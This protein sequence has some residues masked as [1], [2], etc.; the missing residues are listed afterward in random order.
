[1]ARE[2]LVVALVMLVTATSAAR[3]QDVEG[4]SPEAQASGLRER[5]EEVLQRHEAT[6]ATMQVGLAVLDAHGDVVVSRD[7]DVPLL[8]ASTMKLLT[9]VAVADN[10]D[11]AVG[12]T[13][14]VVAP[15]GV[16]ADGVAAE[17]QV[18]GAGDPALTT[19]AFRTHVHPARPATHLEDLADQVVAAGVQRITGD[20]VGNA[21]LFGPATVAPGW[22]D[23]Y[24]ADF[25]ARHVASLAT[26]T[27]LA[28]DTVTVDGAEHL[29]RRDHAPSP[30]LTA[31]WDF[32]R[33][34]VA[35]GVR[36]DG[37]VTTSLTS[38]ETA[39][40]AEEV[41]ATTSPP[42]ADLV[43]FM[44]EQSDNHMADTLVR[45][46]AAATEDVGSW[47]AAQ[48]SLR[49]TLVAR[50]VP[51]TGLVV[52]DGSGLSR[53]DRVTPLTLAGADQ[54]MATSL[55]ATWDDW[56]STAG[57]DG[58]FRRRLRDTVGEARFHA[59]SGSLADVKAMVGHVSD[60]DGSR[61]HFA[62]VANGVPS[63]NAWRVA[64][65]G[66]DLVLTL[67][68]MEDGCHRVSRVPRPSPSPS[69]SSGATGGAGVASPT[70]D[71]SPTPIV[72]LSD[73]S[74]WKRVCPA[75]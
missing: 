20:V 3:A 5:V 54:S 73:P 35:R 23:R 26:N 30:A 51:V 49:A 64:L 45:T 71:P 8:P 66:D 17:L 56:L 29:R 50:G 68:D 7:G 72:P 1:M 65:L 6:M 32:A 34:L 15:G 19:E 52:D 42:V 11:P 39:D 60:S 21:G 25:D 63:G 27:G 41:A 2:W 61:L 37:R 33:A 24:L 62:V 55:G 10:L 46:A 36:I 14:T 59:K 57:V 22:P 40:H 75:S 9:A 18:L 16:D 58:T 28:V 53:L 44:L 67:A 69:P 74:V 43:Q 38:P 13:T 31:A 12:I 47:S 4:A 48:R 70:P